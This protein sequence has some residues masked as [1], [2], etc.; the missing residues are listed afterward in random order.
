MYFV[1][2]RVTHKSC[3]SPSGSDAERPEL[4]ANAEHWYDI[5]APCLAHQ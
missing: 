1:T 2:R 5:H 4:H 3:G